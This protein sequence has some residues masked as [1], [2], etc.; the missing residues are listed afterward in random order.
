MK[1]EAK[2]LLEYIIYI[3]FMNKN[4][5]IKSQILITREI[6][7]QVNEISL[8]MVSRKF[9]DRFLVDLFTTVLLCAEC[10]LLYARVTHDVITLQP[11]RGVDHFLTVEALLWAFSA[12]VYKSN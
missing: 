10:Y 7:R 9:Y 5:L 1:V 4:I 2:T 12:M 8:Y 11:Y 3:C 6:L